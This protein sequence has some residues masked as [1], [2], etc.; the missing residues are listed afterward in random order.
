M[1]IINYVIYLRVIN[2]EE[3]NKCIILSF[4][5]KMGNI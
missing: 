4:I 1:V 5:I 3:A 2:K